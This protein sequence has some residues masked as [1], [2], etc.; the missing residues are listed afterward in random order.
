M[1]IEASIIMV[2]GLVLIGLVCYAS[3]ACTAIV[4]DQTKVMK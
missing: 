1:I 2:K 4:E 3:S